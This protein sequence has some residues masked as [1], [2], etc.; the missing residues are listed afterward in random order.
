[1]A[2]PKLER[3]AARL[4]TRHTPG[5]WGCVGTSNHA[6]DYRLTKPNGDTLPI[7]SSANDHS[8]Q[9]A[10]AAFI[11]RACNAHDELLAALKMAEEMVSSLYETAGLD[12]DT[13]PDILKIRAAIAKAEGG[14]K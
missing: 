12:A 13:D 1:M 8:E 2:S 11:V 9:R 6:H 7:N 14:G 3:E 4:A 5:P 10:N